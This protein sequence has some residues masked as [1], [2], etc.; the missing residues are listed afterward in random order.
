MPRFWRR[1]RGAIYFL[2]MNRWSRSFL[3]PHTDYTL[4]CRRH[5]GTIACGLGSAPKVE[6]PGLPRSVKGTGA[7][8]P[9]SNSA[10]DTFPPGISPGGRIEMAVT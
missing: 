9:K 7:Y 5:V 4:T 3:A 10:W 1:L 8:V 2:P 6:V